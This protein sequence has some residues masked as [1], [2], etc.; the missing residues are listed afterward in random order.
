MK[1]EFVRRGFSV[2][3]ALALVGV[4]TE[5]AAAP[6]ITQAKGVC[7]ATLYQFVDVPAPV[8]FDQFGNFRVVFTPSDTVDVGNCRHLYFEI[9]S[10][11][12]TGYQIAMGKL[13]GAT[14]GEV[15]LMGS[16]FDHVESQEVKGPQFRVDLQGPPNTKGT[17]QM[18]FYL[19][20]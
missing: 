12:A 15:V 8:V 10:G 9:A 19:T 18:W 5:A 2:A 11:T 16:S 3:F 7:N 4:A 13:P 1:I 17:L 20:G 14:L 6:I